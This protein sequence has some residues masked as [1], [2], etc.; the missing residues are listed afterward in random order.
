MPKKARRIQEILTDIYA[1]EDQVDSLCYPGARPG[2]SV[3]LLRARIA[4]LRLELKAAKL[5]ERSKF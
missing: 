5:K 2:H 1:I 4:E 3:R